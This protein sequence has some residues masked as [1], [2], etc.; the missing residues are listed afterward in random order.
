MSPGEDI[1]SMLIN[2]A[3]E[4]V[5]TTTTT[6]TTTPNVWTGTSTVSGATNL[7]VR[8]PEEQA[9]IKERLNARNA[10]TRRN[11]ATRGRNALR[12][13][14]KTRRLENIRRRATNLQREEAREEEPVTT[15]VLSAEEKAQRQRNITEAKQRILQRQTREPS[16]KSKWNKM[17]DWRKH[18]FIQ[19]FADKIAEKR[20]MD[21]AQAIINE[22]RRQDTAVA[23]IGRREPT[24]EE[25]AELEA[26]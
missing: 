22:A 17:A 6:P 23:A 14:L 19:Q 26:L 1:D 10:K 9:L 4:Q 11:A 8:T 2:E 13:A 15:P 25:L 7:D 3:S 21:E 12:R 24:A 20:M 5:P 16:F 18:K